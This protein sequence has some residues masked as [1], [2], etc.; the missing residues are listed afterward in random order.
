MDLSWCQPLPERK[1]YKMGWIQ[2]IKEKTK[3]TVGKLVLVSVFSAIVGVFLPT[4]I[5]IGLFMWTKNPDYVGSGSIIESVAAN[6]T[7]AIPLQRV[8]QYCYPD[9][10]SKLVTGYDDQTCKYWLSRASEIDWHQ[11]IANAQVDE[12]QKKTKQTFQQS[13]PKDQ[14]LPQGNY[15]NVTGQ[16]LN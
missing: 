10:W 2:N 4:V 7:V 8:K 5:A 1:G 14:Q 16:N 3:S 6:Q 11:M 15:S 13:A 12:A 9:G